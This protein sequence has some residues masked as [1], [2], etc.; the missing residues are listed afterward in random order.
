M[1]ATGRE[2][3]EDYSKG[4]RARRALSG[5]RRT[6]SGGSEG[7][8]G[9]LRPALC[10]VALAG[11]VALAVAEFSTVFEVAVGSLDTVQRTVSG[12]DNH[13]W[14]LL[15][16]AIAAMPLALGAAG[17]AR[18]PALALVVL[19]AVALFIV[20]AIDLPDTNASGRLPESVAFEDAQAQPGTGF[21]LETLGAVLLLGSGGLLLL[22]GRA[23]P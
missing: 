13:S 18:P 17:G 6:G 19:G 2:A 10:V 7:P 9:A 16:V 20:L 14:A 15:V 23:K 3:T 5:G 11:A 22:L 21:Y 1:S 4:G 12:G 8:P